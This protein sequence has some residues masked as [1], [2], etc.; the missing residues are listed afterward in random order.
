MQQVIDIATDGLHLSR[1]RGFLVASD[2]D[3]EVGRTPLDQIIAVIV[4]AHGTTCSASLLAE[5]ADRGA[6]VVFCGTNHAPRSVLMPLEGHHAQGARMRAQWEA[7][8]AIKKQAWKQIVVAKVRMQAAVLDAFGK[9]DAALTR[10][11]KKVMSGDKTNIEAQAARCYW[12][13]LMGKEFRRDVDG[14]DVNVLL[15]YGYTVL[16]AATARSVVAAGLHPTVSLHHS[17][18]KN[19]FGLADDLM[20]PFRPLVD[21]AARLL[22]QKSGPQLNTDA[23]Q[24]MAKLIAFDMQFG[25]EVSPIS[26]ALSKLATSLGQSYESGD[27][28]L[29]LPI[30]PAPITLSGLAG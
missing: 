24:T 6:P 22:A 15:N 8:V 23:K 1:A 26:V 21:C 11:A 13:L 2:K 10:M 29:S 17:S 16:R 28:S 19:S 12:P 14:T 30:P 9:S 25:D 27:L 5:L 4:H 7:G 20:E 3:S 18:S